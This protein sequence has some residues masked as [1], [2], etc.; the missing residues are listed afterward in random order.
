MVSCLRL[1]FVIQITLK[2]RSP[3]YTRLNFLPFKKMVLETKTS[4]LI[5]FLN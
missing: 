4:S 2:K 1:T 5:I 3:K